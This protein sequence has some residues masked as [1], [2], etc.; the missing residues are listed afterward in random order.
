MSVAIWVKSEP[1]D[2]WSLPFVQSYIAQ[3]YLSS[4]LQELKFWGNFHVLIPF[5]YYNQLVEG[6]FSLCLGESVFQKPMLT[7][8]AAAGEISGLKTS[9]RD[10]CNILFQTLSD[11]TLNELDNSQKINKV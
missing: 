2:I 10:C 3:E 5:S 8:S 4:Q 11:K 6:C 7:Q 9:R 1:R